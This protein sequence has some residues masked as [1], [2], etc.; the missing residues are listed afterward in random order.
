MA[1]AVPA[2]FLRVEIGGS[3]FLYFE[4]GCGFCTFV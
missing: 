4:I 1:D 3:P 2:L